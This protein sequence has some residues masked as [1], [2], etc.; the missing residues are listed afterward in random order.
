[1]QHSF[2]HREY[3]YRDSLSHICSI[4][5]LSVR[6]VFAK[7]MKFDNKS[8]KQNLLYA[9][10]KDSA[11]RGKERERKS[12]TYFYLS[13]RYFRMLVYERINSLFFLNIF[14]QIFQYRW[15]V[16]RFFFHKFIQLSFNIYFVQRSFFYFSKYSMFSTVSIEYGYLLIYIL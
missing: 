6:I 3:R 8:R 15:N 5:V 4:V 11:I 16:I 9:P 13:T 1:M 14:F 2:F 12:F 10:Y 7:Q